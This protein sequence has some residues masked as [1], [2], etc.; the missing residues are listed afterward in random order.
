MKNQPDL[1]HENSDLP[2]AQLQRQ[3]SVGL[4]ADPTMGFSMNST[5]DPMKLKLRCPSCAKLYEVDSVD[6]ETVS[7]QFQCLSCDCRF[8]FA[9]PPMNPNHIVCSIVDAL[10]HLTF[11]EEQKSCPKCAALSPVGAE[12]CY[13]CCV[14]FSRLVDLP[15]DTSLRAQPSLVRKWKMLMEDFT[16]E[17]KHEDFVRNC[18]QLEAMNFAFNKYN[19]MKQALGGD[20]LCERMLKRVQKLSEISVESAVKVDPRS[21]TVSKAKSWTSYIIPGIYILCAIL[22]LWG[23]FSLANRNLVGVGVAIACLLT[24]VILSSKGNP[25]VR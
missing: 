25:A 5:M 3:S 14:I 21:A 19:D 13:S 24:G 18:H 10:G 15:T 11:Q 20:D 9:Y 7:P 17:A 23:S 8:T 6:I 4:L 22:I 12:E 2:L 16:D 1:Q